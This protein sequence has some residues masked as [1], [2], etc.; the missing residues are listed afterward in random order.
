MKRILALVLLGSLFRCDSDD[1]VTS[2]V[3]KGQVR[4]GDFSSPIQ[5]IQVKIKY[6]GDS[7]FD[8]IKTDSTLTDDSGNYSFK[9]LGDET[10]KQYSIQVRDEYYFQCNS[11][12]PV[13]N[14]LNLPKGI[15]KREPNADTLDVCVT[16]KIKLVISKLDATAQD[17]LTVSSKI[18]LGSF[19]IISYP[20]TIP[21]STQWI[22]YYFT[23]TTTAVEYNFKLKKENGDITNWS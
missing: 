18:K 10:I 17:T 23:T 13:V 2:L 12:F 5:G 19:N 3:F 22:E 9:I 6:Y 15:D 7:I 8:L 1:L 21:N 11:M 20:K 14:G 16:G 4:N